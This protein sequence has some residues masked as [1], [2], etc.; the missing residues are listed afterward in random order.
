MH[1]H[2]P[3]IECSVSILPGVQLV[4]WSYSGSVWVQQ[5]EQIYVWVAVEPVLVPWAD[6]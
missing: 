3:L 1:M 5:N 6:V 2:L 4:F